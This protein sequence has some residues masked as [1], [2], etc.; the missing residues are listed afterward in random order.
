MKYTQTQVRMS[1]ESTPKV[2]RNLIFLTIGMT[3]LSAFLEPIFF[4][5]LGTSGLQDW[6][7]LSWYGIT[8]FMLWQPIT[9]LFILPEGYNGITFTLL[10]SLAF[11]MYMLWIIGT[12]ILNIVGSRSFTAFYFCVGIL[13]GLIAILVG[14][15]FLS[16]QGPILLALFTVWMMIS[17]ESELLLFLMFPV[18]VKWLTVGTIAGIFL[19]YLSKLDFVY[20]TFYLSGALI[21]YVYAVMAWGMQSPFAW[22]KPIDNKLH[23]ISNS[24]YIKKRQTEDSSKVI[25][26]K[27]GEPDMS[28]D[29]RF[30]DIMLTKISKYGQS[31]LSWSERRRLDSISKKKASK[32]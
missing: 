17:P 8:H 11:Q 18:K 5:L 24:W 3:L 23:A 28:D 25:N 7:S 19:I 26:F 16:G 29:D 10:L 31:S 22:T 14:H 6:L 20:M 32:K 9:Y 2:I 12:L 15:N 27:T 30:V 21:G 13:S 1:P 4:T